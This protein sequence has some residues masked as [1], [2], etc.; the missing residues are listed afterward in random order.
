MTLVRLLRL[1]RSCVNLRKAGDY[2]AAAAVRTLLGRTVSA[3]LE[4]TLSV[5]LRLGPPCLNRARSL[6]VGASNLADASPRACRAPHRR[7]P[8]RHAN[9]RP[10]S[11]RSAS[12]S[13]KRSRR[14]AA[15]A[16]DPLRAWS[17]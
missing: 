13:R 3:P 15:S 12:R 4:A 6:A 11:P 16:A 5:L 10:K 8:P 17:D 7:G 9:Y 2:S 1:H 14:P